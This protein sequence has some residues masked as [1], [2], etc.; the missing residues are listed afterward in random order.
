MITSSDSINT[1]ELSD[2]YAILPAT[3]MLKET[4]KGS[5]VEF[6]PVDSSFAYNSGTNPSFMTVEE[7]RKMIIKHVDPTFRPS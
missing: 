3:S 7:I 5:A 1:I 6:K 4:Y 2:Y